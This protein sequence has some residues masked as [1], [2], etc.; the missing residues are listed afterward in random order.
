MENQIHVVAYHQIVKLPTFYVFTY[1]FRVFFIFQNM[2]SKDYL[3]KHKQVE[4]NLLLIFSLL[5]VVVL[6][7]LLLLWEHVRQFKGD[8]LVKEFLRQGLRTKK[9]GL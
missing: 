4:S 5:L 2:T 7:L 8:T 9:K 3:T 6:L 1:L